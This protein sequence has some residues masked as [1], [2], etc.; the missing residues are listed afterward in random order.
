MD[1]RW[2]LGLNQELR[3]L[4]IRFG[5]HRSNHTASC[6]LLAERRQTI[7]LGINYRGGPAATRP[8]LP[9]SGHR[10]QQRDHTVTHTR[11]ASVNSVCRR[12]SRSE[13]FRH[14]NPKNTSHQRQKATSNQ[15]RNTLGSSK[16][17]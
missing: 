3:P 6:A 15:F 1:S 4:C 2:R 13:L 14:E 17:H 12:G 11:K 7:G 9:N 16:R 8:E 10:P 5:S